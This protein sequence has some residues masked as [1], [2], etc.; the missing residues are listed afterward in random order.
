MAVA[1]SLACAGAAVAQPAAPTDAQKA[2]ITRLRGILA[3]QHRQFDDVRLAG[4]DVTLHLGRRFYFL[5]PDEA[6]QVLKEWGNP[7]EAIDG[8]LGIIFP[9]GK[10]FVNDTWGAVITFKP[11]GFV[12]D[13]DADKADYDKFIRDVQSHE[14]EDNEAR[15]KSG[16][17]SI[18]LVGWAQPPSYDRTHHF[19]IWARDLKFGGEADDTLNYD[20]RVL[21]RRGVLSVNLVSTMP[22]LAAVR[23]DASQLAADVTFDP[24]SAYGDFRA[25]TDK[26]AEYG[27]AGLVAA[28]LGLAAAQ[29]FG[30]LAVILLFAKKGLVLILAGFAAVTAWFRRV[31]NRRKT[32]I[33]STEPASTATNEEP[34]EAA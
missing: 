20:L 16:F 18:H 5:G 21:G 7:P 15:K 31:F 8:V 9:A 13:K 11:S 22:Q 23:A 34:D 1:I 10:T 19:L 4:P 6:K 2:E 29:K 28:G 33:P 17:A 27:V 32:I 24:G 14:D 25:G 30:L 26:K 12:T 3:A